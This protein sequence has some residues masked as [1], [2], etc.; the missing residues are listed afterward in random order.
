MPDEAQMWDVLR[1]EM[2]GLKMDPVRVENPALPGTPDVN[3]REGW[4]ELK[5]ADRWPPKGGPLRLNHPPTGEQRTWLTRRWHSGGEAWLTIRVG[6]E[7]LIFKGCDVYGLYSAQR[8]APP[9]REELMEAAAAHFTCPR[10][11]ADFLNKGRRQ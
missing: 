8:D 1:P 7:W 2:A 9:D 10:D 6:K 11:V 4:T 3:Y 5:H